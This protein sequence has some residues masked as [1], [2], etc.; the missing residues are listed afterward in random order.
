M[1]I[2]LRKGRTLRVHG[3]RGLSQ[4]DPLYAGL[5]GYNVPTVGLQ[6]H[7]TLYGELTVS[8]IHTLSEVF[9]RL[10]PIHGFAGHQR[11]FYDLGSGLGKAVVGMAILNPDLK[12]ARGIEIVPDRVR[13]AATA[14]SRVLIK[15]LASRV[16]FLSG[17]FLSTDLHYRDAAWIFLSNQ[18]FSDSVQAAL[19][20]KLEKE[21]SAG[22][23]LVCVKELPFHADGPFRPVEEVLLPMSWA[24]EVRCKVYRRI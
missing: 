8:G 13:Q 16:K 2:R 9:R 18:V 23:I 10:A 4:L 24:S 15:A 22:M 14:L 1:S 21:C 20:A 12:T 3:K 5:N 11:I 6:D 17:S 7:A 19:V